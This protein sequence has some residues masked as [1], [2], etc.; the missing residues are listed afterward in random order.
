MSNV[1]TLMLTD[2]CNCTCS[3]CYQRASGNQKIGKLDLETVDKLEKLLPGFQTIQFFGGEPLLAED[4]IFALDSKIDQLMKE[5]VLTSKPEYVFSSNLVFLSDKFKAFLHKLSKEQTAFSFIITVDGNKFIHNVN[6]V[7]N[8]G[9]GTYKKILD[10][11]RFLI[12]N[13]MDCVD[14]IYVVYNNMH[15]KN[16]ISLQDCI[17]DIVRNFP[18]VKYVN[19]NR[20]SLFDQT[21]IS[22]DLFFELKYDLVK[23]I[24]EDIVQGGN[25]YINC[26]PFLKRELLDLFIS[27]LTDHSDVKKCVMDGRKMSVIPTGEVFMCVDQYYASQDALASLDQGDDLL[28]TMEN[29]VLQ[30]NEKPVQCQE[31]P[32][33]VLCRLC[34]MKKGIETDCSQN[35]KFYKMVLSYLQKTYSDQKLIRYFARYSGI[36]DGM[37][38]SFYKYLKG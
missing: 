1:L 37:I 27:I 17:E 5:Q 32:V 36:T 24:F 6:R 2:A 28:R 38:F 8:N 14:V 35:K 19:F 25:Q 3:Y 23:R 10:N 7:L 20:E 4:Y 21:K 13:N 9:E 29:Y 26:A 16:G 12:E 22:E 18:T 15:Y 31:C 30:N 33:R 11:Y 34:P